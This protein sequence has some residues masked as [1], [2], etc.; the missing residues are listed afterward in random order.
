MATQISKKATKTKPKKQD[1][2]TVSMA[3]MMESDAGAGS[4]DMGRD[5]L[6]IP[7]LLIL[8]ALSPQVN[9]QDQNFVEGA[10]IG[11]ILE[12]VSNT[13]AEGDEGIF[14][15]PFSYRLAHI[16]WRLRSKAGG[17]GFV[18]D[19][20]SDPSCL[21]DCT[22]DDSFNHIT[23]K[24]ETQ[25]VPTAEYFV[26]NVDKETGAAVPVVISMSGSQRKK[27]RKWNTMINQLRM[28]NGAGKSFQPPMF[29]R[30]YH[31][32]TV[33]ESNDK[34][35][36]CGWKITPDDYLSEVANGEAIYAQARDFRSKIQEGAIKA[37]PHQSNISDAA[38]VGDDEPM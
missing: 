25:I 3:S 30:L 27:S 21:D 28:T 19:H 4:E 12:T 26:F 38:E 1:M 16:E 11:D 34:G 13:V 32:Q 24:G 5:D 29:C 14:V 20:G 36:W 37:V 31:L 15:V 23:P 8:Q 18:A 17:G 10:S 33:P 7:R 35:S 22:I 6:A 2:A 9:K